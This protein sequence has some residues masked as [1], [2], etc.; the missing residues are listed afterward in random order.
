MRPASR[1]S[2]AFL[3][4]ILLSAP[5][6]AQNCFNTGL[7]GT[8]INLACNQNCV[9][10]PVRIPHLKST[11]DYI[12]NSIPYNPYPYVTATGNEAPATVYADDFYSLTNGL[13]FTFCFYDSLFSK[14]VY[15]SNG[16][17]T[18]DTTNANCSN[19]Y[20]VA[21]IIPL[22]GGTQCSQLTPYYPKSAVMGAY[23]DLDPENSGVAPIP[24]PPDRKIQWEVIGTAPCRKLVMSYYH[25]GV[26]RT[27]CGLTTPNTFQIVLYESTGII[28]VFIEQK[29]C[30]STTNA[31]RAILGIQNWNRDK[32]LA[33]PGKNNTVWSETN[34]GYRFVPSG[35]ASRFVKCE[36]QTLAGVFIANGDTT[37]TLAGTL[38]VT[39]PTFCPTGSTGQYVIK[40]TFSACDNPANQIISYDTITINKTSSLNA[41]ESHTPTGCGLS[42][43]GTATINVPAGIGTAPY[44]FVLTPGGTTLTG[45]S[46]QVFNN[47]TAGGYNVLVTDA[48]GGCTSNVPVTITSSGVLTVNYNIVHTTCAGAS[49]GSI[50]VIP[51]NG[52]PPITYSIN[53][54]PFGSNNVF[55]ALAP[56]TYFI[57]THDAAGCQANFIPVTVNQ[58]ASITMSTSVNPTSCPGANNGSITITGSSGQAPLQ[59]SI[60]GGPYQSNPTFSGLAPGTYFISL[61]DGNGCTVTFVPVSVAQGTGTLTGTAAPTPT[62]CAGVNDGKIIVTPTSGSGPY[63]FSINNGTSWQTSNTFNGLAPGTYTILIREGGVCL[64]S[65]ITV[66]ITAGTGLTATPTPT[67]TSCPGVNNGT[68]AVTATGTPPLTFVLDGTVTQTSA[69]NST[70]FNGVSAGVHTITVTAVNGCSTTAAVSTTVPTGTG[71]TAGFNP[72]PTG[73]AGANNGALAITPQTPQGT[74]PFTIVLN[75]GAITQAGSGTINFAGLASGTYS[76]L[77]TDANGCQFTINNM[78]VPAGAGLVVTPTPTGTSCPGVNNGSILVTSNGTAPIT[79]ILDGTVTQVSPSNST[80]FTG[81]VAGPHT[82]TVRDAIGCVTTTAVTTTIPTGT[83]YTA[84]FNPTTTGCAGANNGALA[85]TPQ[86]PQG[87]APFTI[88]L[89]PGAITQTGSGQITFSGLASGTYSAVITDANGC[90]ATLTN[91]NVP[92]G[93]GLV[94]SPTPTGTSCPGV[95]NGSILVTS[96]G[97]SP[98]TFVLDGTV[99]QVSATNSTTFTNLA[100][101]THSI[102]VSDAIGCITTTAVTTTIP[103]G[104]GYTASFSFSPTGC[105]GANNGSL[106]ITPQTPQGTAPF[107]I[108]L[109]PGAISQTGSGQITFGGLAAGT[110]SAVITDANGCQATLSN[111]NVP[112]GAGLLATPTPSG[113]S[114]TGVNNGSISIQMGSGAAPFTALMDGTVSVVGASPI[115]FSGVAA[116]PHSIT[117][118]DANGCVTTTPV[119]TTVVAGTGF[120]VSFAPTATRCTGATDGKLVL[121]ANPGTAPFTAVLNPGAISQTSPG[122]VITFNGL[123]AGTYNALVTDAN[124]CQF[125][126]NN[127]NVPAGGPLNALPTPINTSCSGAS[128]GSINVT[129]ATNGTAPYLYSLNAG[130]P[131][132]SPSFTG[133]AAGSY[134]IIVTDN[135]GCSSG[136]LSSTINQGP[137]ISVN[138]TKVDATCFGSS[139]GSI[140]AT[141]SINATAPIQ[142]SLDNVT[143]QASPNFP[144]LA[145]GSYTVYIRDAVGCTNSAAISVGQPTQLQASTSQQSVLCNSGSTGK[146]VVNATGGTTPYSYSLDNVTF[147]PGN[148]FNVA[149]GNYTIYVKDANGCSLPPINASVTQPAQLTAASVTSNATCDGGN[150]GTITI[151]PSGGVS[152]YQFAISG[153]SYQSGGNFNVGPGTYNV[154]VQDVNGCLQT[155]NGIVVGLTNN[156]TY[157]PM[158]DPAPIC[159]SKSVPLQ[160]VTNATQFTWTNS[161]SL[162]NSTVS[163]PVAQPDLPTLFTVTATLGRCT[164]SDDVYVDV[165]PAPIPIAGPPGD[166][167]YGQT[168]QLQGSGGFTYN[169]SP[170]TNLSSN[171]IANPVVTPDKTTTYTLTVQDANG[172]TSLV[173]DQVIVKVT[174]PIKVTTYPFDTVV[175]A[176]AKIQLLATSAG[177]TYTWT[178]SAGLDNPNVANPVAS[179]PLID[180][181][182]VNYKVTVTTSAG[183][184]GDGFITIKV[185]KGPDIYVATAFSPNGDGRNETFVPFPVGIKKLNYFKVFNRWGQLLFSTTTLNKGWDGRLGGFEQASGVYIWMVEGVTMDNKIITKNGTVTLIR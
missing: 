28:E 129:A 180:G 136:N 89:N 30:L 160:L 77:I 72:T 90:Q 66:T 16:L 106:A 142:Y 109:N 149:A 61:I 156:L 172:C 94:A 182:I 164:I 1:L 184:Q 154:S 118:T 48:S 134:T 47:L 171:S 53:G 55:S 117:I 2:I 152:P 120:T 93:A 133:L 104:T 158:V 169:W 38:D 108:I 41:T 21:S 110:Y 60:N 114:C 150:D 11:S 87:T 39:F 80:T 63:E 51:P 40:T 101:G 36:V 103:T 102:T 75:P 179:A 27:N 130:T 69:T 78:N 9:N 178:P 86:T 123:A 83:G 82:I 8:V 176:G 92:S 151:N 175:F 140:A 139:T 64:S 88:V 99:T 173:T 148:T 44:T 143:W 46:P 23:S 122:Q 146:I 37:T 17:L 85:I 14:F 74:A 174:P 45:N 13:S 107:T 98:L 56:G 112:A 19:A 166:I 50:T 170:S 138:P 115:L 113:T 79:F 15:G 159:Q 124:G 67:G 84:S 128:N 131:Q 20:T 100:A 3:L 6:N 25:I 5:A 163:N 65:P 167:C 137:A 49:N 54:G 18:F 147:Q 70:T 32:G 91:M 141:P 31:G 58:G 81:L 24:S 57:S 29:A 12:V 76:A 168:Y 111:M 155:V 73:C 135:G 22:N 62:S 121:T 42:G 153:G 26:Y 35:G 162:S 144:N 96:N 43:S 34:T 33:A 132:A 119:T 181:T 165:I 116:G 157:T 71:F 7:N 185:Y 145:A 4:L 52:T 68:I 183:C 127:M 10:V 59:Y 126:V 95:N 105:A 177:T 161:A 125:T 97:T